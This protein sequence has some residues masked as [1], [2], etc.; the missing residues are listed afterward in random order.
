MQQP[1]T[2]HRL[3]VPPLPP[4]LRLPL[5]RQQ[6]LLLPLPPADPQPAPGHLP[7]LPHPL[8]HPRRLPH[9]SELPASESCC[10]NVQSP[11]RILYFNVPSSFLSALDGFL[12][13]LDP[14]SSSST[15]GAAATSSTT[16]WG[17]NLLLK[18]INKHPQSSC[19]M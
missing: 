1:T 11:V 5:H 13:D 19:S 18:I 4:L 17:G 12:L 2:P 3:L 9:P 16:G 8:L 14:M 10:A 15:K 6:S 7:N